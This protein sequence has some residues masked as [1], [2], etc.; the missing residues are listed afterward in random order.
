MTRHSIYIGLLLAAMPG[1]ALAAGPESSV[2]DGAVKVTARID[3]E[4]TAVV[5]LKRV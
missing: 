1:W 2:A 4:A 5:I 3:R